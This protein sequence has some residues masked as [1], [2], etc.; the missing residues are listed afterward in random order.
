MIGLPGTGKSMLAKRFPGILPPLTQDESLEI[1]KIYSIC[2]LMGKSRL[3]TRRPF[4]DPHHTI[5][6]VALIGGGSTPRP[7]KC[8][9][10]TTA[11]CF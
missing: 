8:P 10:R 7:A 1:T 6:D 3:L 11:C 9:W 2:N 5:S 4:R